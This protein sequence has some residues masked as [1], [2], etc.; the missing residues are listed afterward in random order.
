MAYNSV[1][2]NATPE[3]VKEDFEDVLKIY[4]NNAIGL[5]Q[6][7][8]AL[9]SL[10]AV[11][12]ITIFK[13]R[14]LN[15]L[16]LDTEKVKPADILYP[17]RG[18]GVNRHSTE[19]KEVTWEWI[20]A[21]WPFLLEKLKGSLS[22]LGLIVSLAGALIGLDRA[23]EVEDWLAGLHVTDEAEKKKWVENMGVVAKKGE[24]TVESMRIKSQW[25]ERERENLASWIASKNF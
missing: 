14:V 5:D 7:L 16:C 13:E 8:A 4:N 19:V 25:V 15:E 12:D 24:Q 17:F 3:T 11:S 20:K 9:T 22:L 18:T 6:R 23:K 2:R 10:G 1:L 21:N